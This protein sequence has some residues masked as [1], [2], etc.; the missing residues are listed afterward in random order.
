MSYLGLS[1]LRQT[2]RYLSISISF[3]RHIDFANP[4]Y[5]VQRASFVSIECGSH[6]KA[7]AFNVSMFQHR[8]V[9]PTTLANS[10]CLPAQHTDPLF[11]SGFVHKSLLDLFPDRLRIC[12]QSVV[13]LGLIGRA[14]LLSR[15]PIFV[16]PLLPYFSIHRQ[17][18]QAPCSMGA[19]HT[20]RRGV[21]R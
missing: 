10:S 1:Y 18:L 11:T 2:F 15:S 8:F 9:A 14:D 17:G 19:R 21:A 4:P 7:C 13:D 5:C 12:S 16:A 6:C 20:C 3:A